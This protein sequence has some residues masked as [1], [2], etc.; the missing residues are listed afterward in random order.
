MQSFTTIWY[1]NTAT[2]TEISY[3]AEIFVK[4]SRNFKQT[5]YTLFLY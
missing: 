4:V 1:S 5:D 3:K 2:L